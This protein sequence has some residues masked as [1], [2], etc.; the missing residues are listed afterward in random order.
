VA[1]GSAGPGAGQEFADQVGVDRD[2]AEFRVLGHVRPVVEERAHNPTRRG[3]S[4]A[5]H[6]DLARAAGR[7][8]RAGCGEEGGQRAHQS[9]HPRHGGGARAGGGL[10]CPISASISRTTS[11]QDFTPSSLA[12]TTDSPRIA[13][14][15]WSSTAWGSRRDSTGYPERNTT[16]V[17]LLTHTSQADHSTWR[18]TRDVQLEKTRVLRVLRSMVFP[19]DYGS[20]H[21]FQRFRQVLVNGVRQESP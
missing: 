21:R 13:L 16:A 5:V 18:S 8:G 19:E 14:V 2:R 9:E 20:A 17:R 6:R 1:G 7:A 12:R 10:T 3:S 4:R 15:R 11:S